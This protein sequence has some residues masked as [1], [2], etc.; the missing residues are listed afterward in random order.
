MKYKI[1]FVIMTLILIT[2]LYAGYVEKKDII[3]IDAKTRAVQGASVIVEH[4]LNSIDGIVNTTAFYTDN[5]G[6]ASIRFI[7]N[8]YQDSLTDYNY[9][10][11]VTYMSHHKTI[12]LTA[13][14]GPK[15][16]SVQLPIYELII[17]TYDQN[18]KPLIANVTVL[19]MTRE[20][21]SNGIAVFAAEDGTYDVHVTKDGVT[22][23]FSVTV[24][25][26][27][28]YIDI[29]LSVYNVTLNVADD[30]G[31]KL[32]GTLTYNNQ[33]CDIS[34]GVCN[35][36]VIGEDEFTVKINYDNKSITKT[37]IAQD[38]IN[39]II[40]K[41]PPIID[42]VKVITGTNKV[43]IQADITD[44]GINPSGISNDEL[45][46]VAYTAN[47]QGSPPEE[48]KATMLP[49]GKGYLVDLPIKKNCQLQYVIYAK[50]KEG[51]LASYS[52]DEVIVINQ[53]SSQH[54]E[55][56]EIVIPPEHGSSNQNNNIKNIFTLRNIVAIVLAVVLL[57][58]ILS[59]WKKSRSKV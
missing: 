23:T 56:N 59:F 10:V 13:G 57:I 11:Y 4:Q 22:K 41:T 28:G 24:A 3:V 9:K 7:N 2:N 1:L 46:Y 44:P 32:N 19:N 40:D 52:G 49:F 33:T 39:L 54:N 25:G 21:N 48:S 58:S 47:Y 18:N 14:Q 29:P 6:K 5:S 30:N 55:N 27:D 17:H 31:K 50:D 51:N 35:I 37:L 36:K 8:E 43:T 53:G 45:P 42:N 38:N 15:S 12:S 34:Y 20:T 16:V 26:N